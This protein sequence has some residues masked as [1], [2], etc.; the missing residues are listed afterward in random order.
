[1]CSSLGVKI[2]ESRESSNTH[3]FGDVGTTIAIDV[4]H[5]NSLSQCRRDF[6]HHRF[7]ATT[8]PAPFHT[9]HEENGSISDDSRDWDIWSEL[10]HRD[11]CVNIQEGIYF[12]LI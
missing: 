5:R 1:M 3:G 12:F 11:T 8:M 9:H 10:L 2:D 6:L 7:G 4:E